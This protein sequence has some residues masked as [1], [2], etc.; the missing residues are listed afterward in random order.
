MGFPDLKYV[1]VGS[2]TLLMQQITSNVI[3]IA[4]RV[5]LCMCMLFRA[6]CYTLPFIEIHFVKQNDLQERTDLLSKLYILLPEKIKVVKLYLLNFIKGI[7]HKQKT[8][9]CVNSSNLGKILTD[10][11]E[12][13]INT[14]KCSFLNFELSKQIEIWKY[15]LYNI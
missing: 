8:T 3:E 1:S 9:T 13:K 15:N 2:C 12:K 14:S 6:R 11:K 7:S 5:D 4:T 10:N